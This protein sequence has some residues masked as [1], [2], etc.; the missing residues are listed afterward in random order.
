MRSDAV[1]EQWNVPAR[2]WA[3]ICLWLQRYG[4]WWR[5]LR[6]KYDTLRTLFAPILPQK[7]FSDLNDCFD[8]FEEGDSSM[9]LNRSSPAGWQ[10]VTLASAAQRKNKCQRFDRKARCV[11]EINGYRCVCSSHFTGELCD[12]CEE[13][14]ESAK[15]GVKCCFRSFLIKNSRQPFGK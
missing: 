4:F 15:K 13:F 7:V 11:D 8:F 9:P 6:D 5:L 10:T 2:R 12:M 1:Q 14:L 3:N